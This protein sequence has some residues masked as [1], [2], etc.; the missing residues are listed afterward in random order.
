MPTHYSNINREIAALS[1]SVSHS[2]MRKNDLIAFTGNQFVDLETSKQKLLLTDMELLEAQ[3]TID[4]VTHAKNIKSFIKNL[5]RAYKFQHHTDT[6][7][8]W[9]SQGSNDEQNFT[10]FFS[11]LENADSSLL[12]LVESNDNQNK[13]WALTEKAA[14]E[15]AQSKE[16]QKRDLRN[17]VEQAIDFRDYLEATL[18]LFGHSEKDI[19]GMKVGL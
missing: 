7:P 3:P 1:S 10:D 15:E 6:S 9:L 16:S 4:R 2:T 14:Y 5:Q 12:A 19:E 18:K 8:D 17:K 11:V 13:T